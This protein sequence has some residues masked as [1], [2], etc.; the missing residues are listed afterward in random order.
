MEMFPTAVWLLDYN[1]TLLQ[2]LVFISKIHNVVK[3][4]DLTFG[5]LWQTKLNGI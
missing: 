1:L 4:K 3:E 2:E 5:A